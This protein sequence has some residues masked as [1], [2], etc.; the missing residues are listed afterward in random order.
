MRAILKADGTR[1]DL[2]SPQTM[3]AI[4]RLI[5]ASSL[6]TVSLRHM[7]QPLHVMV[8]D[9]H[10]HDRALPVNAEA[11][12]LYHLNCRPGTTHTIRGDVVVVPD[13]DFA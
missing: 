11:T 10:G 2:D 8:V 4:K 6:D 7:G 3:A 9:D 1:Q 12:R 5:N 13:A